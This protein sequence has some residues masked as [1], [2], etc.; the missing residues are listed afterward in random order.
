[1]P[2]RKRTA[3][4]A[5][6]VV[7]LALGLFLTRFIWNL[8]IRKL[9]GDSLEQ[10]RLVAHSIDPKRLQSLKGNKADLNSPDYLRIK[11]QLT[12]IRQAHRTCR[13][14]YL[15]GRKSD[16]TVFIQGAREELS[17]NMQIGLNESLIGLM[18][19]VK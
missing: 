15:M 14:L 9:S 12:Q 10:A 11:E 13:F 19:Q 8:T 18:P 16:G 7:I 1:M 17:L 4:A 6:V 2:E 5:L 3:T